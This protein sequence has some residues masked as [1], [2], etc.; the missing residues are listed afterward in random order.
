MVEDYLNAHPGKE[1]SPSALGKALDRSAGAV[2][3]ALE[4]LA[5]DGYAVKTAQAPKRFK[6]SISQSANS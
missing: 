2:N 5:S 3:N 1:F 6:I 4:K